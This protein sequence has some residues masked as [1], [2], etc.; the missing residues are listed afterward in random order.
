MNAR[1]YLEGRR[2]E[3]G[4]ALGKPLAAEGSATGSTL[5]DATRQHLREEAEELYW[6]ELEWEH[7][8]DE[9][10]LDDDSLTE[11]AFP[12][13]L[14]FIRGLLLQKTLET[15]REAAEP[16]PEVVEDVLGF[17][18]GR[19][20]ELKQTASEGDSDDIERTR[21]ENEMTARLVDL[22]L[23]R[24]HEVDPGDL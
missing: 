15:V 9:E 24:L 6:N 12:G 1:Q 13:F 11:Q 22:V 18:A 10:R 20:L 16:R 21:R 7:I 2:S 3:L 14:A 17:L 23:L 5:P 4:Q 8:T 19:V